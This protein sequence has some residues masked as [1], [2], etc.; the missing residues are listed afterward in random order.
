MLSY[1]EKKREVFANAIMSKILR[2][3]WIIINVDLESSDECP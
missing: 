2:S 3:F 1:L